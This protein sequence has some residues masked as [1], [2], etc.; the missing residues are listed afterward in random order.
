MRL[1]QGKLVLL[2]LVLSVGSAEGVVVNGYLGWGG[3]V[4]R[5][6]VGSALAN[7]VADEGFGDVRG[8]EKGEIGRGGGVREC[9]VC[10][11]RSFS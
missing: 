3:G 5:I 7:V 1:F 10:C 2:T 11:C 6:V 8:G 9:S 4:M